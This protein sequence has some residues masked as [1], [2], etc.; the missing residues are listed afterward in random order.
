MLLVIVN[1]FHIRGPRRPAGPLEAHAP[2]IVDA[3]AVL[4]LAIAVQRF[5][6][7]AGQRG[8]VCERRGRFQTVQLHARGTFHSAEGL[9]ALPARE[10]SGPLVPKA[11]DHLQRMPGITR[12]VKRIRE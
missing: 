5:K 4:A 1:Y 10:R 2:L 12:Y 11:D 3:Y 8:K 7:V 6:T 9:D